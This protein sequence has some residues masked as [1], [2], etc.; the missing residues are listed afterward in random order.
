MKYKFNKSKYYIV[1]VTVL[2]TIVSV[3][4]VA[5]AAPGGQIARAVEKTWIGKL[6][7]L[8]L[9]IIL[10]PVIIYIRIREMGASSR[11]K[12][13]LAELAKMNKNFR[14]TVINEQAHAIITHVYS[15]WKREDLEQ[16][17]EWM[18]S[19]YLQNQQC[20]A[21]D[22][23][24]KDGL[25]NYCN[26]DRIKTIKPLYIEYS[27]NEPGDGEGTRI[28]LSVTVYLQDYLADVNTN[29]IVEGDEKYKYLRNVWTIV[30]E[31]GKWKL[32][33]IEQGSVTLEY[34]NLKANIQEASEHLKE[35]FKYKSKA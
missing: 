8:V 3:Y 26:L 4:T 18:T 29:E 10:L 28:I 15:A 20:T 17:S 19:W 7:M 13:V 23:W 34:T 31:E 32:A 12:K 30:M 16:A 27:E 25:K 2:I 24:E 1:F 9:T 11:N 6:A 35:G 22:N 14:W 33:L 5:Y 21:L